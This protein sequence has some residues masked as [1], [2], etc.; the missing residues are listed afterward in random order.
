MK[1]LIVLGI[2]LVTFIIAM[3]SLSA[4]DR[5]LQHDCRIAAIE[6]GYGSADVQAVCG[7]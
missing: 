5:S 2:F 4:Y 6:K 7:K 1:E 3:A